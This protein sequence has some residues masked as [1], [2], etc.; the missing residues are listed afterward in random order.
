MNHKIVNF[1]ALYPF[2][3][4]IKYSQTDSKSPANQFNSHIHDRCEI[5]FNISG[6]VSFIVENHIYPICPG[7]IIITRPYEYHHCVYHSDRLHKHFWILFSSDKNEFLY[8]IF[9]QRKAGEHN[10]LQLSPHDA[11]HFITLCH[12]ILDHNENKIENYA[13]YFNLIQ[14]LQSAKIPTT[15]ANTYPDDVLFALD[16]FNKHF[17]DSVSIRDI[18]KDANVNINTLERHFS[19]T[20]NITPTAYLRKKRLAHAVKL[21]SDGY[22]VTDTCIKSGFSDCSGFISYFKKTYGLTP[23]QYKK[24]QQKRP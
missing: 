2:D 23:L 9:F 13:D 18:A 16:Y 7:S 12:R 15:A 21:L 24:T 4:S 17:L 22:S 5:Y 10:L 3:F 1:Q 6:D 11:E 14:S 19:E 20:L 8:D